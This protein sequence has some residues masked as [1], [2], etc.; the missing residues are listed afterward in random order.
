M[1][2]AADQ[3][4]EDCPEGYSAHDVGGGAFTVRMTSRRGFK[5]AS[6]GRAERDTHSKER[7]EQNVEN[8]GGFLSRY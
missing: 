8:A 7:M 5:K 6:G 1:P 3:V 2:E 4:G